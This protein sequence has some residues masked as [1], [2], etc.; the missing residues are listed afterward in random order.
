MI[1]N[2]LKINDS[3]T[4]FL[5]IAPKKHLTK[6]MESDP[7]ITIGSERITPVLTVRNLG[8]TF[9]STMS[10]EPHTNIAVRN[11]YHHIRRV[12]KIRGHLDEGTANK[13]VHALITSRLDINN[14]LLAGTSQSNIRRLQVAQN[15]TARMLTHTKRSE[16]I[17]PV[18]ERLHW[19]PVNKR[20]LFKILVTV[21]KSLHDS[22]Y[23]LYLKEL[24]K[25]HKPT[26]SLRSGNSGNLSVLRSHNNYGDRAFV[27]F[28]PT[29][30]NALSMNLRTACSLA[31]FKK[32]LKT[33]I[34]TIVL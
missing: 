27:T 25:E 31:S 14:G 8:S 12:A 24:V 28:A 7:Y 4:E 32:L 26:R 29:S 22:A 20:I 6:I 13:V 9:D 23:P 11:I 10:M 34:L 3:K 5:I 19:L 2:K 1:S 17:T 30:L 33:P 15:A 16:H 18:L 21:Y